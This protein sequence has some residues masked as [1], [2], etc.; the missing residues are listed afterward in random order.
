MKQGIQYEAENKIEQGN[1]EV[2]NGSGMYRFEVYS[3]W[4][5]L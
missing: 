1:E 3:D 5:V 2:A 4:F